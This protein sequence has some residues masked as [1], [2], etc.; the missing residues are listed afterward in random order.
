MSCS[1][2]TPVLLLLLAIGIALASEDIVYREFRVEGQI[3]NRYS[4]TTVTSVVFN[5]ADV[6]Q[7]LSFRVQLPDTAFISN[8]TMCACNVVHTV[9][10]VHINIRRPLLCNIQTTV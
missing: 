1:L 7:E 10:I 2:A 8:F 6:S 9:H 5:S 3:V 4:T